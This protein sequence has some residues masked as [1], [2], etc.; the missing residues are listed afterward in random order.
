[1]DV[2]G[3]DAGH[4][5]ALLAAIAFGTQVNFGAVELEGDRSDAGV[6]LVL[7]VGVEELGVHL[8]DTVQGER[9]DVDEGHGVNLG[10]LTA[11]EGGLGVEGTEA[12]LD[13]SDLSFLRQVGLVDEDAV[14]EGDLRRKSHGRAKRERMKR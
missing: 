11:V 3:I 7:S 10:V 8:G 4:K 6:V 2:G 1:M 14:C 12:F 13:G 5:L 9:L